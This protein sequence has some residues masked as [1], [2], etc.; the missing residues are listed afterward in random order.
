MQVGDVVIRMAADLADLRTGMDQG[1]EAVTNALDKIS[2]VA[3]MAK[4]ALAALGVAASAGMFVD[5]IRGVIDYADNLNDLS[6]RTGITVET[7]GGLDYI[8]K[9]SGTNLESLA[10]GSQK[11]AQLMASAAGGNV[12]AAKTLETFGVQARNAD[13]SLVGLDEALFSI[14]DRFATYKDG[15]EKAAAAQELMSKG[16]KE[17]IPLL[18]QGGEALRAA[19]G[20]YQKYG[21]V[22]TETARQADAFNDTLAKI[23]LIGGTFTRQLTAALLPTMN[24]LAGIFVEVKGKGNDFSGVI[25]ILV[26]GVKILGIGVVGVVAT[27]DVLGRGLGALAAAAVAVSRGEFSQAWTILKEGGSDAASTIGTAMDRAKTIWNASATSI[28]GT[29]NQ[30]T[31]P[32]VNNAKAVE[33]ALYKEWEQLEKL[34]D[35]WLEV[36]DA[37]EGGFGTQT[38]KDL[39][40][41][42]RLLAAGQIGWEQY[43]K[44]L[45][46]VLDKDPVLRKEQEE[47]NKLL[48]ETEEIVGKVAGEWNKELSALDDQITKQQNAN[49]AFGLGKAALIDLTIAQIEQK[50]AIE[51]SGDAYSP[52][53]AHL[54][55]VRTKMIA[56]RDATA[57]GEA[58]EQQK[59]VLDE[60]SKGWDRFIGDVSAKADDFI[61]DV[62]EDGWGAAFQNLWGDFKK[63]AISAFAEIA[64]KQVVVSLV[65][66]VGLTGGA[67]ANPLGVGSGGGGG[68]LDSLMNVGSGLAGTFSQLGGAASTFMS[69]L[70]TGAPIGQAFTQALATGTLSLGSLVPVV[71]GVVAAGTMIY[72]WLE[73]KR[74]G[75]KDGGFATTGPTPGITGVD[76][77]GRWMTPK[78]ADAQM[79]QAV[80]GLNATF[81]NLLDALGGTGS[82]V[83]AQ[84]FST[85]PK[86]TAPSNV[87]TGV[88]VNGTQVFD[89][90]N[91]NVG[92]DDASLQ[93][94]LSTQATR[95]ILA[96]LQA[97]ELPAVVSGYLASIDVSTATIDQINAA[98]AH[99][100]DLADL[101]KQVSALPEDLANGL[102][103]ALGV[104]DELDAKIRDFASSFSAFSKAADQLQDA[105]DR[106]PKAE[107]LEA[108]AAAHASTFDKVGLAREALGTLLGTYD[109][110]K[111]ATDA[112]A[113][114]T[115]AY[116]DAQVA[117]LIQIE[118]VR[119]ALGTM[120]GDTI[121]NMDLA[122]LSTAQQKQF[123]IDEA[124]ATKK[125]LE[126]TTDPAEIEKLSR[127]INDD[128]TA[129]FR[130]MDPTEQKAQHDYLK[131]ILND[132]KN[133]TDKQLTASADLITD[134]GEGSGSIINL[135]EQALN[136]AGEK[137]R[138]AA[139]EM[140]LTAASLREAADAFKAAASDQATTSGNIGN[141][142][143]AM[144]T[145]ANTMQVAANTPLRVEI[146]VNQNSG[147]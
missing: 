141:A 142:A 119:V 31:P 135:A 107:A 14:A 139:E 34:R 79:V 4:T 62:I 5:A 27:F 147:P 20:E 26:S 115:N 95:A 8:A 50:I 13:G 66:S 131:G 52:Y 15:P 37:T 1:K 33:S 46:I 57:M 145:A 120:F 90:P 125:L 92:R 127:I 39:D 140:A 78:T 42:D 130:L 128:V 143:G 69:V 12:E 41:L 51:Q 110:S 111:E 91:G 24:S 36:L 108:V 17:L 87:H 86:G 121:R 28:A 129:A 70:G 47:I 101:V 25:D 105:L 49:A 58:L 65:G 97:S 137:W 144:T 117:A 138:Q 96:A 3:S 112:L 40:E 81:E 118:Q 29:S 21:G 53:A 60:A 59:K 82:A 113:G 106:D 45:G 56:L 54:E 100:A 23:E 9:Q 89:S 43:D 10:N 67:A 64:A 84:G 75:P 32:I 94:E 102:L 72:N 104:N 85:D 71:G 126:Q 63:W 44:A 6:Q 124:L 123:Y 98:L 99:A 35:K 80:N 77:D 2:G 109:G 122:L 103:N 88:W 19:I 74:G 134:A 7:L 61:T 55:E 11:L 132:A 16:G 73:S 30:I 76:G 114:A 22:T 83:F 136:D 48:K 146:D 93:A 18:N 133:I 68:I 38:L 116:R